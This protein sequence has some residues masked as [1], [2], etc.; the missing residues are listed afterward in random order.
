M[1]SKPFLKQTNYSLMTSSGT[2]GLSQE[3]ESS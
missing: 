2:R 1:G 3:G